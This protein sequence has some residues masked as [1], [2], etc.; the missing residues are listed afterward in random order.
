M[1]LVFLPA[2]LKSC[3][4]VPRLVTRNVTLPAATEPLN[5]ENLNSDGLPAVTLTDVAAP[6]PDADH[7]A[8]AAPAAA[9]GTS[10]RLSCTGTPSLDGNGTG[11]ASTILLL[12]TNCIRFVPRIPSIRR[13]AWGPGRNTAHRACA[14]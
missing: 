7:M 1:S 2:I 10:A 6:A 3:L 11:P 4:T 8:T 12:V 5:S 13:N 9:T 14:V